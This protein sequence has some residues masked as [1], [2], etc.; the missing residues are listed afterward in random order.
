MPWLNH[1]FAD[2]TPAIFLIL[3]FSQGLSSKAL[4]L[5]VRTQIRRFR[6]FRQ[7][8][9]PLLAGDKGTVYQRRL[10]WTPTIGGCRKCWGRIAY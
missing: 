8:P 5:L 10:F 3:S 4:V 9:P 6:H 7:E 1:A 2:V